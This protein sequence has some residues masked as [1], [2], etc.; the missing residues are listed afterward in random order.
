METVAT[1]LELLETDLF[2]SRLRSHKLK[3][4]LEGSWACSAGY[5]I[6]ILFRLVARTAEE[7]GEAIALLGIGSHEDVY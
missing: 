2:D 1:A 7:G 4:E 5:D 3:G 6:G